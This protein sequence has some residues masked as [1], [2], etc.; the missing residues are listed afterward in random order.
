M[1]RVK[2]PSVTTSIRVARDTFEP[3]RTRRPDGLADFLAQRLGHALG[4]RA[5]REPARL[6]HDDLFALRPAFVGEHERHARGLAGARRRD[7]DGGIL[8]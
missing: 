6:Q 7:Q 4:G 1:S 3:K 8:R 2:M 5:R